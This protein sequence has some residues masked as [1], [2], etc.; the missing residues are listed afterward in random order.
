MGFIFADPMKE[1]AM[2]SEGEK[3]P[4][5]ENNKKGKSGASQVK[6]VGDNGFIPNL[7]DS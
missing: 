4:E 2:P 6:S 7:L 3:S 1:E 5:A